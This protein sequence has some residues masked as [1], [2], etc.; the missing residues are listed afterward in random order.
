M[1][2]PQL[3]MLGDLPNTIQ[4]KPVLSGATILI[5]LPR[6]SLRWHEW[7]I[8]AC[9]QDPRERLLG[10]PL[11]VALRHLKKEPR[12]DWPPMT[13]L[14]PLLPKPKW[15]QW[16][17]SSKAFSSLRLNPLDLS[18]EQGTLLTGGFPGTERGSMWHLLTGAFLN[19]VKLV[20]PRP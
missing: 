13:L 5:L 17:W 12:S 9:V 4:V 8:Q 16:P 7:E 19:L 15:A 18:Q 3:K 10:L 2:K 6:K 1:R 14:N 11:T 20:W